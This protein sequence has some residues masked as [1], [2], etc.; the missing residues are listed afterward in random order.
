MPGARAPRAIRPRTLLQRDRCFVASLVL[1]RADVL[2]HRSHPRY[3]PQNEDCLTVGI[4]AKG[5]GVKRLRPAENLRS[6]IQRP[7]EIPHALD[8]HARC[9]CMR[10]MQTEVELIAARF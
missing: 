4:F 1:R 2:D 3:L 5:T 8:G 9:I 7:T 10:E 6:V